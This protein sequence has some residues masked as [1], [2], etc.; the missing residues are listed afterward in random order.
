MMGLNLQTSYLTP[1]VGF[2]LFYLQGVAR[3]L[4]VSAIYFGV[5]PFVLLQ[6]VGMALVWAFPAAATWLPKLL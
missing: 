6:I 3:E 1:P 5:I 4:P 2:A